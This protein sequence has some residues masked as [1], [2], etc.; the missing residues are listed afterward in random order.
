MVCPKEELAL[1]VLDECR[2]WQQRPAA[3]VDD[4]GGIGCESS[5]LR[6]CRRASASHLEPLG[7]WMMPS[8][9]SP[10]PSAHSPSTAPELSPLGPRRLRSA[11][12][13][14]AVL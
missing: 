2:R 10:V 8:G 1:P 13:A 11:W 12:L 6:L 7:E 5:G 9:D 3:A 14:R 4:N